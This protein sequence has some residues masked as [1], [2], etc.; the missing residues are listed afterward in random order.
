MNPQKID[1]HLRLEDE[2]QEF[3]EVDEISARSQGYLA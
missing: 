2:D 1:G 3:L